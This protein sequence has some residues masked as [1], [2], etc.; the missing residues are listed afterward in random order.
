MRER[1]VK[2]GLRNWNS[3]MPFTEQRGYRRKRFEGYKNT[4]W[5]I[6]SLKFTLNIKPKMSN[7]QVLGFRGEV[8]GRGR[9]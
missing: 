8:T 4:V 9:T 7:V 5:D 2:D 3:G 6:L 1:E